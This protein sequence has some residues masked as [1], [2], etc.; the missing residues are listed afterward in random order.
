M[1]GMVSWAVDPGLCKGDKP[2][3]GVHAFFA[4]CLLTADMM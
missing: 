2:S 4:V 3:T 1:G